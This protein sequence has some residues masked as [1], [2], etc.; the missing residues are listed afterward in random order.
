MLAVALL[1]LSSNL[2]AQVRPGDHVDAANAT[3]VKDLLSPGAYHAVTNGMALNIVEHQRIDWPPPFRIAT[4]KYSG[5]VRLSSDHR[6]LVGY[7]AGQPF[8]LLDP[9]DPDIGVKIMWNSDLRPI[10]SDDAD[11]RFFECQVAPFNPGGE[12]KLELL[13]EL[14]HLAVYNEIGRTEV[15][16]MPV[17]PDFRSS[18]IWWRA[19]AYPQI[20]PAADR[21]SG[22]LRY[23]YWD[24][25][26][27][28]DAWAYLANSR[29]VQRINEVILSSSPGLST[30]DADHA[31]GFNAKPQEYNYKFLGERDLLGCVHAKRSPE[32]PCPTDGRAT[33]C[34]DDWEMRHM[35]TVE[36]TPRPEKISGILE[37]R[38]I[39]YID[40]ELWF[41][42]YVDS[43]DRK[44]ELWKTQIYLGTYRDR[45]VPD[46][47]VA[48]YPFER[49]FIL[50]SS[51]IDIQSGLATTCYLPAPDTTERECWYINMG[52]VDRNFFTTA[53]MSNAGH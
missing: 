31:G 38:T 12:Q 20:A 22:G 40:S 13:A 9:D 41:N 34:P 37:S 49:E 52:A 47:K 39:V 6:T 50:A 5:Q 32:Q 17:D 51:S 19:A 42:S 11:L 18:G 26:R 36:V 16:P 1:C 48:I 25:E 8:P 43:Y 53:A 46:A 15:E 30:W 29:R 35:Y 14:G 3:Q 44:G 10:N 21:G 28:D 4:E 33:S 45:S 2:H 7:V 27:A 23:R 24:P